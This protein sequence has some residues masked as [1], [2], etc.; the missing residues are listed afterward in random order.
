[1]H[2]FS[3]MFFIST[4]QYYISVSTD[5]FINRKLLVGQTGFRTRHA[6]FGSRG[7]INVGWIDGCFE[8][9][10]FPGVMDAWL[11]DIARGPK[12]QTESWCVPR[13]S[14]INI[15]LETALI[16]TAGH[17]GM[18]SHVQWKHCLV[19]YRDSISAAWYIF[20]EL[21]ASFLSTKCVS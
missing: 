14:P 15:S 7:K 17:A 1:M 11:W 5:C 19:N 20:Y 10:C 12:Q 18:C 13:L 2:T 21:I 9:K 16:W 6:G 8:W 3:L 4:P